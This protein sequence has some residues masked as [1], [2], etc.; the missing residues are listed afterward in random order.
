[1]KKIVSLQSHRFVGN[2]Y[3]IFGG[4]WQNIFIPQTNSTNNPKPYTWQDRNK[5]GTK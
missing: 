3:L 2:N 1:M 5:P 4:F